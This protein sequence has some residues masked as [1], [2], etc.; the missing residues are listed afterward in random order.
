MKFEQIMM[1]KENEDYNTKVN[2]KWK[3][4]S[5]NSKDLWRMIDWKGNTQEDHKELSYQEIYD[6]FTNIFQSKKT[7]KSP[8]ISDIKDKV[9]SYQIENP[10][11]DTEIQCSEID[12]AC[13]N[14]GNGTG[15]DGIPP[16]IAKIL[17]PSIRMIMK[18]LRSRRKN[19][20]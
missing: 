16:I 18:S 17:P 5:K 11:T 1:E 15:V 14:A 19:T 9:V 4:C 12:Y 7:S 13:K 20:H 2:K 8:V 10:T 6:F 3:N